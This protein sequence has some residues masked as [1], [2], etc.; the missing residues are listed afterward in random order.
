MRC[1]R[2][3]AFTLGMALVFGLGSYNPAAVANQIT[4]IHTGVGSGSL[5]RT[6]FAA[7]EF[8]ITAIGDTAN[9]Q[10]VGSDVY[11]IDHDSAV[12]DIS[13]VGVLTFVSPTRTF[14]N[15]SGG[16]CWVLS[17]GRWN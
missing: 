8:T 3:G 4:F 9:R 7:T 10:Q 11:F 13:G 17:W 14:V 1:L 5:G 16:A 15:Q 2:A 6:S 12:I